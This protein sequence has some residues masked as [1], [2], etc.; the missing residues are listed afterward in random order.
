MVR[1]EAGHNAEVGLTVWAVVLGLPPQDPAVRIRRVPTV[2]ASQGGTLPGFGTV[3][4]L[5]DGKSA[6]DGQGA[7]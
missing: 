5:F 1:L 3:P 2:V 6:D 7:R 4:E